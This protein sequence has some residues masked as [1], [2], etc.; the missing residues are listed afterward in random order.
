MFDF[1]QGNSVNFY[2]RNRIFLSVS[3]LLFLQNN[4]QHTLLKVLDVKNETFGHYSIKKNYTTISS[5][6]IYK[7]INL[8]IYLKFLGNIFPNG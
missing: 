8:E 3:D 5:V 7:S 6:L 4:A 1:F 2:L